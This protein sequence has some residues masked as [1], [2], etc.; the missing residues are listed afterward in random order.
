MQV[1]QPY[2]DFIVLIV[3]FYRF[4]AFATV[5]LHGPFS[6]S[7]HLFQLPSMEGRYGD[8]APFKRALLGHNEYI[9][10]A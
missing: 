8:S 10:R 7:P 4:F 2:G 3:G 1:V 5:T 9:I 6:G